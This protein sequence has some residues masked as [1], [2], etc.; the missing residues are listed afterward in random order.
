MT[1]RGLQSLKE[2]KWQRQQY[3]EGVADGLAGKQGRYSDQFYQKGRRRG[4]ERRE[5]KLKK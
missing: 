5:R 3:A 2:Y 4:K 1:Q